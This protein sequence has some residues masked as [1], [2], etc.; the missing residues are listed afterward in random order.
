MAKLYRVYA[1][2]IEDARKVCEK[3]E[4][5]IKSQAKRERDEELAALCRLL[6]L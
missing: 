2:T 5:E 6:D 4:L 3:R 1:A